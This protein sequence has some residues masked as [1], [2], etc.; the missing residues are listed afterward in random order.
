[1]TREDIEKLNA[2]ELYCFE[3]DREE[4]WYQVGLQDGLEVADKHPKSPWISVKDG[5]P[6]D[7]TKLYLIYCE[8]YNKNP[9]RNKRYKIYLANFDLEYSDWFNAVCIDPYNVYNNYFFDV[10]Y[11][12]PIPNLT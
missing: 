8:A 2:V 5:L 6:D 10:L 9:I 1:M 7:D 11:W 4:Q 3:T 12:M